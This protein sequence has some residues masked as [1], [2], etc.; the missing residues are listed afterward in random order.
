MSDFF[1]PTNNNLGGDQN[2][3]PVNATRDEKPLPQLSEEDV[4][5]R[6]KWVN[7]LTA[8]VIGSLTGGVCI[9]ILGGAVKVFRWL[10][11]W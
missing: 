8:A 11:G 7:R 9:V 2:T 4:T 1:P 6:D 3:R 5:Y 10:S